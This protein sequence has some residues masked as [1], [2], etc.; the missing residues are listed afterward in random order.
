MREALTE[1]KLIDAPR[2]ELYNLI[3][4]PRE[5]TSVAETHP[6]LAHEG[7]GLAM[8]HVPLNP[9]GRPL[10]EAADEREVEEHRR[11]LAELEETLLTRRREVHDGWGEKYRDRVRAK[12]KMT[13]RDRVAQLADPG[14][15]VYEIGTFVNYGEEFGPKGLKSPAAGLVTAFVRVEPVVSTKSGTGR[16]WAAARILLK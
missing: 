9:I 2:V 7:G 12:G 6:G 15:D 13:T 3:K 14:T 8:A 11:R 10:S 1:H 16:F 4:D 5:L